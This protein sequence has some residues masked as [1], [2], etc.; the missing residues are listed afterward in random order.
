MT[1]LQKILL[2]FILPILA[3]LCYPLKTIQ[4]GLPVITVI[5]FLFV[6]LGFAQWRGKNLALTFAIF[7][8]GFNVIIRIMMFFTFSFT[9]NG[10][11]LIPNMI[12]ILLGILLSLYLMLRL[13]RSDI[14]MSMAQ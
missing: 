5:A 2:F 11:I 12:A 10:G 9:K 6:L 14:R 7:V 3:L 13:D 4:G 8:Q 1:E